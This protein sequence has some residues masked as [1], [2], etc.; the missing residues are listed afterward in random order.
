MSTS[1]AENL[2]DIL[3]QLLP[4]LWAFS[5][6]L[7]GNRQDAEDLLQRTC[8]RAL[9]RAHQL[10]PGTAPLSWIYAI[11]QSIWISELRA[12]EVRWRTRAKWNDCLLNVSDPGASTPEDLLMT[13]QVIKVVESLPEAQRVV[14]LLV[15]VEGLSYAE[16]AEVLDVPIGTVMSRLSRARQSVGAK[17]A[18]T[19]LTH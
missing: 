6:R 3:P 1:D 10:Q 7:S 9:E 19:A 12:R 4:K 17:F 13:R 11:A 5:L 18:T 14:L 2:S 15:A 8:A 16:A